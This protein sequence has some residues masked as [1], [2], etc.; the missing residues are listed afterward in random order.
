[1]N[2]EE[3]LA[4]VKENVSNKNLIKYM[5]AVEAIMKE[6]AEVKGYDVEKYSLAGLCH[7]AD[8]EKTIDDMTKHGLVSAEMVE[9]KVEQEVDDC[10]KRHNE[11]TGNKPETDFD[12]AL[13][14]AD[15]VSGLV[16]AAAL[17]MPNKKVSE[18]RLET[19][20]NKFKKKDFARNVKRENVLICEQIG[21]TLDEFLE[22]SLGALQKIADDLGL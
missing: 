8:Y 4:L 21:F 9:G 3:A 5:L 14:A 15:A 22:L 17:M 10:I 2:R 13:V 16:I 20:Q 1:M 6:I 12:K 7:D 19:L 18:V 11:M